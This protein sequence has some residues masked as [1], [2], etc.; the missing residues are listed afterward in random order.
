M[1]GYGDTFYKAIAAEYRA[2]ERRPGRHI[3][4][5]NDVPL[6][7]AYRWIKE[8]R[9]RGFLAPVDFGWAT[10]DKVKR[11]AARLGVAPGDLVDA[12]REVGG[13]LRLIQKAPL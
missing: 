12:V 4:E 2:T 13:E 9:Q 11:V 10:D 8:A 6:S 5:M 1:R 3:A 7:T